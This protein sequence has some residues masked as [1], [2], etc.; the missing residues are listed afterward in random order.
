[1]VM[2]NR[3]YFESGP[4]NLE[5]KHTDFLISRDSKYKH[6]LHLKERRKIV[7]NVFIVMDRTVGP[8]PS[9]KF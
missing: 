3:D 7:S 1:M 2:A 4:D 8:S 5:T 9:R 6:V